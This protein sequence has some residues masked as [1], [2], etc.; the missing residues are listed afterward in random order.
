MKGLESLQLKDR[1]GGTALRIGWLIGI[2]AFVPTLFY[3]LYS[4]MGY[5]KLIYFSALML[6]VLA[7][8]FLILL[9]ENFRKAFEAEVSDILPMAQKVFAAYNAIM[10]ILLI[11][12]LTCA[13]VS[14]VFSAGN[15]KQTRRRRVSA[16]ML[17][18]FLVISAVTY[19][20]AK[21]K[22]IGVSV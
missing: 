3:I 10:P 1:V 20:V 9:N 11:L 13:V 16:A 6:I 21:P 2:A 4:A 14:I 15:G 12:G 8:F 17:I 18:I 7:T 22:L 19:Y 5:A